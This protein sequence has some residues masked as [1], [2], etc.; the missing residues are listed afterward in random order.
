MENLIF[1]HNW[2]KKLHCNCFTTIRISGRFSKGNEIDILL[3]GEKLGVAKVIDK[4]QIYL[5]QITEGMAYL[6]TGYN[7]D[8][9]IKIIK[10]MY[11][12]VNDWTSKPIYWYLLKYKNS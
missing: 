7:R 3:K 4:K 9:T 10:T 11:P 8:E 1:S 6:D 12:E 5:E 2:N